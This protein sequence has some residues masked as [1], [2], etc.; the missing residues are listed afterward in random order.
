[1]SRNIRLLVVDDDPLLRK[2]VTEQLARSD[3]DASSAGSG[4]ECLDTLRDADYDVVLLDIMMP[5]MSGL[6]ALREIRKLDDP[7]E[8]VMLTADTSLSTGIEAM[9]HGAYDYLTKPATL[10]EMEAVLHK[11]D[12]KRRL[13]KQ[14]ASLRS[15]ARGSGTD[16]AVQVV[17]AN[18]LMAAV[19]TEAEAAAR[20]D[21]TILLTGES[22]SGKDVLARYIHSRSARSSTPMITIN[23]GALPETLFESE[24][25]GHERGA[26]TGASSLRRGLLEAADGST[27]FLDEIGDM[28]LLMQVKLLHFLEQGRFRRVGSTRDQSADVRIIAATNRDLSAEIERQRF[29]ADLYYRLNVV[30]I[31]VPPLRERPEDIP[32]LIDSFIQLYRQRFNRPRLDVSSDARERL[33]QYSWP[34][35]VREL[36]NFLER[37]AAIST[38]DIIDTTQIPFPRTS[39]SA[40][41]VGAAVGATE[42]APKT[43]DELEREHILRVLKTS[44]GNRERAAAIL[45][46]SSRTLYRK[47]REYETDTR[48]SG[49]ATED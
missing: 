14:N 33:Q 13:I 48:S 20:T 36:R 10:D 35:N 15:V 4:R 17:H 34:G 49:L 40:G 39:Q 22:G 1:M 18:P 16:E 38:N 43:L 8:V 31:Q 3:F 23:C 41:T 29:R 19:V 42:A 11:A 27:L 6:D 2:L 26:F 7:P 32:T 44:D 37:A 25:F 45:G 28:P 21:S 46:I 24:F 5:D 47:I 30:S 9:R 12:E